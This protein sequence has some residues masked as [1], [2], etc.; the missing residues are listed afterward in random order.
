VSKR[1]AEQQLFSKGAAQMID[2]DTFL[3]TLYV[4][5][6]EYYKAQEA[7]VSPQAR[8]LR[9][10]R[11]SLPSGR[12]AALSP[13]EVVT[14]AVFA[15]WAQFPSERAFHRYA[16]RHLRA[17]FPTL[18]DR[19]QYNRAVRHSH[20][21][22]V[23]VSGWLAA[24]LG[25]AT[26]LYQVVDTT[27]VPTRNYKRRH[28]GWLPAEV[29]LGY[30]TRVGWYQ[31]FRV[32]VAATEQGIITGFGVGEAQRRDPPLAET[33]FAARALPHPDLRCVGRWYGG[34][35]VVDT[36]FEGRAN[37]AHWAHDL[38][39]L[40]VCMPNRSRPSGWP[41]PLRR[42]LA[43]VRQIAET[44]HAR[45]MDSFG[46]TRDRPHAYDGFFARLAAKV[47][48]HNFCCWLNR[49]LGRPVLAFADLLDW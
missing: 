31:G 30:C 25:A 37:R 19:G 26:C 29:E 12:P 48:L 24:D 32:L 13:S 41:P 18:P 35:Y 27:G 6:D 9:T 34:Y 33:F 45:L 36:G 21:L 20:P 38:E 11:S 44:V 49:R 39:A 10:H 47:A 42:W 2:V 23:A 1:H 28:F 15:Q 43:G 14:L 5:V 7:A 3:T 16:Q 22:L 40:T 8:V 17:A 4:L 46:L